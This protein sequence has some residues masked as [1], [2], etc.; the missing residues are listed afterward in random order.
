MT[1]AAIIAGPVIFYA[2]FAPEGGFLQVYGGNGWL[3]SGVLIG[4]MVIWWIAALWLGH[5]ATT[6]DKPENSE[7]G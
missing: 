3:V 6:N 1:A 4:G 7:H 5:T 2:L